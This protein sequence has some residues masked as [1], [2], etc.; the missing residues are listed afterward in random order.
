MRRKERVERRGAR[1]RLA[2]DDELA[3]SA[4]SRTA[5]PAASTA[6]LA[7]AC[8]GTS[9]RR[10]PAA[11]SPTPDVLAR[12]PDEEGED[13]PPR[14]QPRRTPMKLRAKSS[15]KP[16]HEVELRQVHAQGKQ[17]R[18]ERKKETGERER[19][20][21]RTEHD[22]VDERQADVDRDRRKDGPH[23]AGPG[24]RAPCAR[25]G[26][27]ERRCRVGRLVRRRV[28]V[29]VVLVGGAASGTRG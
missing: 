8:P 20:E 4:A 1:A 19:R 23:L 16:A 29:V 21:R 25:D 7:P 11:R 24:R 14:G 5:S 18:H 13:E 6:V 12:A 15:P 26:E 3:H 10:P 2:R 22:A 28:L 27:R 9:A 17:R